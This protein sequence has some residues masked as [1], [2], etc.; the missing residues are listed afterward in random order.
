MT[1]LV[2]SES[3]TKLEESLTEIV[4][5]PYDCVEAPFLI[6]LAI[7]PIITGPVRTLESPDCTINVSPEYEQIK[8]PDKFM[9]PVQLDVDIEIPDG[10]L[11]EK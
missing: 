4:K 6:V 5:G 8:E 3:I 10:N 7:N 9:Y 11:I 2:E 1:V